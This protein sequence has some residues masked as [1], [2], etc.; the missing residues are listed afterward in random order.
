MQ[1]PPAPVLAVR[2]LRTYYHYPEAGFARAVDGVSF[3]VPPH[4]AV[5]IAG[6]SGSGKTQTALSILGLI[7]AAP[8]IVGG[9]VWVEGTDLLEGIEAYCTRRDEGGRLT[10][11]KDVDRWRAL[12]QRRLARVR[13]ERL[14]MVF[15]EPKSALIPYF[16]VGQHLRQTMAARW[17]HTAARGYETSALDLLR[18]LQFDDP[19]RILG[20][21]PYQLSGGESQRVMLGLALVGTPRL[22]IADEPT[23]LLDTVTQR[24]VLDTL[25]ALVRERELALLL[26]THD[27]A[28]MRLLVEHVAVMFAGK[29][30]EQGPVDALLGPAGQA[31]HPYPRDLLRAA[32]GLEATPAAPR[33]AAPVAPANLLGCRYYHRCRLKDALPEAARRRCLHEEPPAFRLG[34]QHRAACWACQDDA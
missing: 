12:H 31:G 26:I 7:D 27:L 8:G 29:I 15:Q 9:Q 32:A 2:D 13:G 20:S 14:A 24:R 23:T 5:G 6:E 21:Y 17:G 25:A 1:P 11:T 10:V 4:S 16:T 28:V 19:R 30:V 33:E 3:E 18:R 34:D 22:L